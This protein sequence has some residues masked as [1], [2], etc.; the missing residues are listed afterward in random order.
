MK[1]GLYFAPIKTLTLPVKRKASMIQALDALTAVTM[2][3]TTLP[4]DGSIAALHIQ[5]V[6]DPNKVRLYSSLINMNLEQVE[7]SVR[8]VV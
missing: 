2:S 3:S 8:Y 4:A 7:S 6:T 5:K 1:L